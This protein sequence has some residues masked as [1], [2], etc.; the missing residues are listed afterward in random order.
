MTWFKEH[1]VTLIAALIAL[2]VGGALGKQFG[3]EEKTIT[4]EKEVVREVVV[5]EETKK[6]NDVK[7]NTEVKEGPVKETITIVR[8]DGTT[9]TKVT[10]TG[11]KETKS[12]TEDKTKTE[13]A[14]ESSTKETVKEKTTEHTNPKPNWA[15]GVQSHWT[16][17]ELVHQEFYKF[18]PLVSGGYRLV[19]D[20]WL[21]SSVM[22]DVSKMSS[23]SVGIGLRVEL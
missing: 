9:E 2:I 7:T 4:V 22:I 12:S 18:K 10:E 21:E 16:F 23:S 3:A 5:K 1:K 13:T 19:G 15:L 17:S 14:V 20:V 6:N 11:P 8:P